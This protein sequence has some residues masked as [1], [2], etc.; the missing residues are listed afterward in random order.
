MEQGHVTLRDFVT[1][2]MDIEYSRQTMPLYL[3][4]LIQS[5]TTAVDCVLG[6][7]DAPAWQQKSFQM[8]CCSL[9]RPIAP[10]STRSLAPLAHG[11]SI[12]CQFGASPPAITPFTAAGC[13]CDNGESPQFL[14]FTLAAPPQTPVLAPCLG[15]LN[16]ARTLKEFE[17]DNP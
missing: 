5:A 13:C 10:P 7:S 6:V 9:S 8:G 11:S 17:I 4:E 14:S 1:F 12:R 16:P 15:Y 2:Y 3:S